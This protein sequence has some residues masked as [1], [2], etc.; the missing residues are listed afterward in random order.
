LLSG[1]GLVWGRQRVL[2][3]LFTLNF[4]VVL[5]ALLPLNRALAPLDYSFYPERLVRGMDLT[6]LLEL[7]LKAEFVAPATSPA[8]IALPQIVYLVLV[9]FLTGGILATFAAEK[10]LCM[11][12][13][14]RECGANFWRLVRLVVCFAVAIVLVSLAIVGL[15]VL[16][17]KLATGP[18]AERTWVWL[19]VAGSA[20]LLFLI[21]T[22]R[23]W[24]DMAQVR[25][26][27]EGEHVMRRT[28]VQAFRQT[29]SN[30]N[31]LFWLY[32]APV[33]LGWIFTLAVFRLWVKYV[34]PHRFG[35]SLVLWEA[36]LTLWIGLR[37][38]QRAIETIWYH[39]K[40]FVE[41][42]QEMATKESVLE[43][44]VPSATFSN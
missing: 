12:D 43:H 4:M 5:L 13:F 22:I 34:P 35:L 44:P 21:L 26:V 42:V 2:W 14:F 16:A 3:S 1:A 38:W 24:F 31:Q 11:A 33:L 15:I 10:P 29:F 19:G 20:L 28:I 9:I 17:T 27:A 23:L 32:F 25:A 7:G 40:R 36:V 30:F 41:P 39:R 18:Y 6:V 8:A 37:L